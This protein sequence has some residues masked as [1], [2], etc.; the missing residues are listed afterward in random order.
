M[1]HNKTAAINSNLYCPL[2]EAAAFERLQEQVN[3]TAAI[4]LLTYAF[5]HAAAHYD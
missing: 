1:L 4:L 3:C 5:C 2:Q